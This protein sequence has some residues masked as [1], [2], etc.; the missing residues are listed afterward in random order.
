MKIGSP[1][2]TWR[3]P[4]FVKGTL[5]FSSLIH[6][7]S[8]PLVL[9]CTPSL[10]AAQAWL[11]EA[12]VTKFHNRHAFL[13]T[14]VSRYMNHDLPWTLPSSNFH[15][16]LLT[17]PLRRL[18]RSLGLSHNLAAP[19]CE[20]L[21]FAQDHRLEFRLLHDLNVKGLARVLEVT[22]HHFSHLIQRPSQEPKN[23]LQFMQPNIEDIE[24]HAA[25]Q[26][27]T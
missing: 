9:C 8:Q 19:R 6:S 20:T 26:T 16:P 5:T 25:V 11:L 13:A 24:A 7:T 17:D 18:S 15:L 4:T 22:E 10:T 21:F 12:H 3:V 27:S 14:L 1:I 23:S 2:P